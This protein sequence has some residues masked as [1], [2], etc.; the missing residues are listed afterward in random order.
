MI[1]FTGENVSL[2]GKLNQGYKL[3]LLCIL[4][5]VL[6]LNLFVLYV[7]LLMHFMTNK[8]CPFNNL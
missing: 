4:K 6:T 1:F 7:I 8:T 3:P 5:V 2:L